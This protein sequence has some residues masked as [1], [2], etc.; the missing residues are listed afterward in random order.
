MPTDG[1]QVRFSAWL[2]HT[3]ATVERGLS[4]MPG[5]IQGLL[6]MAALAALVWYGV[7]SR[8]RRPSEPRDAAR[9]EDPSCF[10]PSMEE[11]T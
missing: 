8:A 2:D 1:W 11:T 9:T 7:R 6:I 3:A 10:E 4:W 5:W